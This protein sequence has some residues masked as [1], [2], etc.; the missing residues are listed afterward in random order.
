M[1]PGGYRNRE[2]QKSFVIVWKKWAVHPKGLGSVI[3][4][5]E[6]NQSEWD[7]KVELDQERRRQLQAEHVSFSHAYQWRAAPRASCH[8]SLFPTFYVQ[9]WVS[10]ETR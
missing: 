1:A 6:L 7:W 8:C 9:L 10:L 4:G 5:I 2:R 3:R